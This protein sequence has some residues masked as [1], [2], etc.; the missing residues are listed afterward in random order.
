M[1]AAI[2]YAVLVDEMPLRPD[3]VTAIESI[4]IE[5]KVGVADICRVR[6][7]TAL[8]D[9]GNRWVVADDGIFGRLS[10]LRVLVQTGIGLPTVAFDG[11]V[12]ETGL[13][14]STDSNV[15]S[16]EV[17]A[18]DRSVEMNLEE[19][20]R[21][22]PN[23]P[24]FAIAAAIF[25]EY[26]MIPVT[27]PTTVVRTQLDTTVTQR[28]TD[29]RFLR[30][31]AERNGFDVYVRPGP[32]P[33]VSEG[34][35]HAPMLDLPP[36]G[37]LSVD[38]GDA[39]N[40]ESFDVRHEM[41][42]ASSVRS[43]GVD[44][45][46]VETQQSESAAAS[47]STLG[48]SGTVGGGTRTTLARPS[49]LSVDSELQGSTQSAVDRSSWAVTAR[50]EIDP[51]VYGDLLRPAATVLVRGAGA[52]HSGTYYV[53]EVTHDIVGEQYRQRFTLR[54]NAVEPIGTEIYLTDGGLP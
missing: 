51:S 23:M 26:G 15:S 39:T 31:L 10:S 47:E 46:R 27:T 44:A 43:A 34:H 3:A 22:W 33:P 49:G 11:V 35:F 52:T 40:V 45:R 1:P 50:G 30:H 7:A 2:T 29:I 28:D 17:V 12:S 13:T 25:A 42:R 19:K 16:F 38:F 8:S 4:E 18:M 36:Q 6:F 9:D 24:D 48:R 54:R 41:L 37:V 14:V 21:Q 32:V 5:S 53:D 20:V